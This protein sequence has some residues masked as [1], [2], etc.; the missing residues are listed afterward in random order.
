MRG[1]DALSYPPFSLYLQVHTFHPYLAACVVN[2]QKNE[3][4]TSILSEKFKKITCDT[5]FCSL[6]EVLHLRGATL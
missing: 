2:E 3:I 4:H 6:F 1:G 5:V